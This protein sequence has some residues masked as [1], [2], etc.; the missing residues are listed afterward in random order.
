MKKILIPTDFSECASKA[1]LFCLDQFKDS[2]ITI[3]FVHV[4]NPLVQ[5]SESYLPNEYI[6][7]VEK[8]AENKLNFVSACLLEYRDKSKIT[9]IECFIKLGSVSKLIKEIAKT[10][11]VDAIVMGTR[12]KRHDLVDKILGSISLYMIQQPICPVILVPREYQRNTV[13]KLVFATDLSTGAPNILNKVKQLFHSNLKSV[14]FLHVYNKN[15][16]KLSKKNF[17]LFKRY[18]LKYF[19]SLN[20][21]FDILRGIDVVPTIQ[22]YMEEKQADLLAMPKSNKGLLQSVFKPTYTRKMINN[23]EVPLMVL[24]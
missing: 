23:L 3:Y 10:K 18:L 9:K 6:K 14:N 21:Q 2:D 15:T 12:G 1:L 19:P 7:L 22:G 13:N 8:E 5:E 20:I 11:N 24:D 17:P 16:S 4:I